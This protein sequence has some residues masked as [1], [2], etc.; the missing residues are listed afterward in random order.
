MV[1]TY[2]GYCCFSYP[3]GVSSENS[4]KQC[5]STN[6]CY[7]SISAGVSGTY[8][9][10]KQ[11]TPNFILQ[12]LEVQRGYV[13]V[14]ALV[15]LGYRNGGVGVVNGVK[16]AFLEVAVDEIISKHKWCLYCFLKGL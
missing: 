13:A 4:L 7:A 12:F 3:L 15:R 14:P 1:L 6:P 11:N 8:V 9:F 5:I 2:V 10:C 16:A